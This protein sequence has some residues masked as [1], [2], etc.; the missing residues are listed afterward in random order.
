MSRSATSVWKHIAPN[1][2]CCSVLLHFSRL[3]GQ[4]ETESLVLRTALCLPCLALDGQSRASKEYQQIEP[5]KRV[6][7][8]AMARLSSMSI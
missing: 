4:A 8:I 2:I 6:R 7:M 5:G 3:G 1:C